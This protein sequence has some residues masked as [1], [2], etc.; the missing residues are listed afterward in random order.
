MTIR[1]QVRLREWRHAWTT[2]LADARSGGGE[3]TIAGDPTLFDPVGALTD[4]PMPAA[5]DYRC[6]RIAIGARIGGPALAIEPWGRCRVEGQAPPLQ[7][8]G[9]DGLQRPSGLIYADTD[10]RAIFLGTTMFPDEHRPSTY[11]HAAGRDMPGVV[12]RIGERR[13]RLV[14]PYPHFGGVLDVIELLPAG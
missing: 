2:G 4:R 12:E 7:L 9:L 13:W 5:G 10:R 11:G 1:D 14:L 6:R 3:A 8:T